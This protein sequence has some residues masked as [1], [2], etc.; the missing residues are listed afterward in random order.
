MQDYEQRARDLQVT[1]DTTGDPKGEIA[2]NVAY[3]TLQARAKW[4]PESRRV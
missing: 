4:N 1:I 3:L 2:E